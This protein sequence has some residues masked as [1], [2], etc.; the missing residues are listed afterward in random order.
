[1][2]YHGFTRVWQYPASAVVSSQ[3]P[4]RDPDVSKSY[5]GYSNVQRLA[6][7]S[8]VDPATSAPQ[9]GPSS[10]LLSMPSVM[11]CMPYTFRRLCRL[12]Q[13][14]GSFGERLTPVHD[15]QRRAEAGNMAHHG[16]HHHVVYASLPNGGPT[17]VYCSRNITCAAPGDPPSR[18]GVRQGLPYLPADSPL[19]TRPSIFYPIILVHISLGCPGQVWS[20]SCSAFLHDVS[21]VSKPHT[22][23]RAWLELKQTASFVPRQRSPQIY[24]SWPREVPKTG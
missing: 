1:M 22:N 24:R 17:T 21:V 4:C 14:H 11:S 9:S 8:A 6:N 2:C 12:V 5:E 10:S 20:R 18:G 19:I 23:T 15:S 13:T 3:S 16:S 7:N